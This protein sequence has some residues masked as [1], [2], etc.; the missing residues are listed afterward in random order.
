M[1]IGICEWC[2][3]AGG[4][5]LFAR[6]RRAG[7]S[8]VQVSYETGAF[9]EK[10]E[11]YARWAESY[12]VT[13]TSVG[14]NVFCERPFFLPENA[15]WV[16]ATVEDVCR[17]AL[18]TEGK[19]F[20]AP[21]FGASTVRTA[22]ER[23]QTA[24]ALR[25]MCDTAAPF[26]VTVAAENALSLE[27]NRWLLSVVDRPNFA[28]Y[29]DTQNPETAPGHDAAEQAAAFV[30]RIPEVHIKDCAPDGRSVPLGQG[31]TRFRETLTALCRGGYDGWLLLENAYDRT[32]D[33]EAA[34]RADADTARDL[35]AVCRN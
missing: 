10:M 29:F 20:H 18:L 22:G 32:P 19:R 26:G 28:L 25:L 6:L 24:A 34:M 3:M 8:G 21:S 5:D 2:A 15:D 12:G 7:L 30:A 16:R 17:G 13:L 14:A 4:E 31:H 1:R 9:S 33:P 23:E 27:E 35:V 11:R